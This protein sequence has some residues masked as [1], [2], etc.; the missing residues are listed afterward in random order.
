[1]ARRVGLKRGNIA[2]SQV[3]HYGNLTTPAR[4]YNYTYL[5]QSNA[6]YAP[7]YI[8]NR[9]A[10]ATVTDASGTHSTKEPVIDV[11]EFMKEGNGLVLCHPVHK[12]P[13]Q[14]VDGDLNESVKVFLCAISD[15]NVS[16]I[17][18]NGCRACDFPSG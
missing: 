10:T 5:H 7:R 15:V 12:A 8:L 11:P 18:S 6:N 13:S 9:L 16:R 2:Q 14:V 4:T 17:E 3:F 1:V